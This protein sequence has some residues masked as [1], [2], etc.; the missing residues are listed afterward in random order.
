MDHLSA[1]NVVATAS[2]TLN[3][4]H[5]QLGEKALLT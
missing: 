4:M 3:Q 2:R 1:L 5:A